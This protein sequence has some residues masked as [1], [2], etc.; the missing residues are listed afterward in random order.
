MLQA[1]IKVLVTSVLVVAI[2][3][4]AKR[5]TL[6]GAILASLPITSMLAMVWLWADTRDP[7]KIASLA[8]GIFWLILPSLT[9]LLVLPLLL[10]RGLPFAPSMLISAMAT[11]GSYVVMVSILGRFGIEI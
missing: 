3:E 11:A 7:E 8:T 5:S 9:M 4:A 10:R 1:V 6:A 2:S